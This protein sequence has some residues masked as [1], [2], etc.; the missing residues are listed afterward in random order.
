MADLEARL[1]HLEDLQAIQQLFVDYGHCLDAGDLDGYAALFAQDGEVLLGP[2]GRARGRDAIRALMGRV[3]EG[4]VGDTYH[5]ISSP[6]VQLDGDT[7]TSEVMWTVVRRGRDGQPRVS[8]LGRHRDELVREAGEWRF[9]SRRG[10]I[11]IPSQ[12]GT[13]VG[14]AEP[15]RVSAT[16]NAPDTR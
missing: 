8:G 3:L 5:V 12:A 4:S 14:V 15:D 1:R 9:R 6:R 10:L 7:A 2:L 13:G 16:S 11:D